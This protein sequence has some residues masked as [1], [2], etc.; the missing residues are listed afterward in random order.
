MVRRR[1]FA[2]R[3][4]NS[5]ILSTKLDD[6]PDNSSFSGDWGCPQLPVHKAP[7][8]LP[9]LDLKKVTPVEQSI[10]AKVEVLK[11]HKEDKVRARRRSMSDLMA[12]KRRDYDQV[13]RELGIDRKESTLSKASEEAQKEED[14]ERGRKLQTPRILPPMDLSTP[15]PAMNRPRLGLSP[16]VVHRHSFYNK[17][18]SIDKP[19]IMSD[20]DQGV[21]PTASYVKKTRD[22][23]IVPNTIISTVVDSVEKDGQV[24]LEAA[25]LGDDMAIALSHSMETMFVL[26]MDVSKNH[27]SDKGLCALIASLDP[28]VVQELNFAFVKIKKSTAEELRALIGE[29]S[30]LEKMNL[31]QCQLD[32]TSVR[33]IS[34]HLA[35]TMCPDTDMPLHLCTLQTLNLSHNK[36]GDSAAI[37]LA[38]GLKGNSSVTELDLSYNSIR[39]KGGIAL[40]V[41]LATPT[42]IVATLDLAYNGIGEAGDT[43]GC[44]KVG[45]A[46][47]ECL[48]QN[49]TLIHLSLSHAG[50]GAG[51]C[52]EIG[53]GLKSNN[54]L[55]GLHLEGNSGDI[56]AHGY[57]VGVGG[58]GVFTRILP[59]AHPNVSN[60]GQSW[61]LHGGGKCWICDRWSETKF[62]FDPKQ[63]E[64][65]E[66]V[67]DK[68][69]G[70]QITTN[71][72]EWRMESMKKGGG[73]VYEICR[74]VPPGKSRFAFN[75][76]T[77]EAGK[78]EEDDDTEDEADVEDIH[79]A[80]SLAKGNE[81]EKGGDEFGLK[82]RWADKLDEVNIL[83]VRS[84]ES[85]VDDI[86]L[87]PRTR[88]DEP[89]APKRNRH[90]PATWTLKNSV[91]AAYVGDTKKW[92]KQ[93][94]E[95]D[96][97]KS[98]AKKMGDKMEDLDEK[99]LFKRNLLDSFP[100][101]K[102]VH[103]H[104]AAAYTTE[105]WSLGVN[106]WN[107]FITDIKV[108]DEDD[109]EGT[110]SS[111]AVNNKIF[112][113][114][115]ADLIF[116]SACATGKKTLN[117]YQFMD[118]ICQVAAS[119]YIK[120]GKKRE[121]GE[122]QALLSEAVRLLA[123]DNVEKYAERDTETDFRNTYLYNKKADRIYV[124]HK[125]NLMEVFKRFSGREDKPGESKTMGLSEYLELLE[126]VNV[127]S[128][129]TERSVKLAFVRSKETSLDE[130]DPKSKSRQLK[131]VE[132]LECCGRLA[133]IYFE[134]GGGVKGGGMD[135]LSCL[136]DLITRLCTVV[137]KKG[138]KSEV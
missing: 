103:R 74:M 98:K 77:K 49:D 54:S 88:A 75:V 104:Y 8:K 128:E 131:F 13:V 80:I 4:T 44:G 107:Q 31:E 33:E 63:S 90:G 40:F 118:A 55:M 12:Q 60:A 124:K 132:F 86:R 68:V 71:F 39:S 115:E 62:T 126:V 84:R 56:D 130:T 2:G 50:L 96:Y 26:S 11:P 9:S 10:Y 101:L 120:F 82:F 112:N 78:G 30:T 113:R 125:K 136:E 95:S 117:R 52:A 119:K 127:D 121:K 5:R 58:G 24:C 81:K 73:G 14:P 23:N 1:S 34:F 137:A 47:S 116:V 97:N 67:L 105:V 25:R 138:S 59:W 22:L 61:G 19:T 69:K 16:A 110:M 133:F 114:V 42:N 109:R 93:A 57:V 102:N 28:H 17:L 99:E 79:L 32:D 3:P 72:D 51:E 66:D 111:D 46:I 129:T 94:F 29:S 35:T 135:F 106:G 91:F 87:R 134:D 37:A 6:D 89:V 100:I 15:S 64:G 41:A 38:E 53:T 43:S 70:V 27:L 18:S 7:T 36:F 48:A 123:S 21:S 65:A 20:V 76:K 108:I 92:L 122:K 45:H 85:L 83:Q